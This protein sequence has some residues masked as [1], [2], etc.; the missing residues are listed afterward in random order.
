MSRGFSGGKFAIPRNRGRVCL[1]QTIEN[2][3]FFLED[4][5]GKLWVERIIVTSLDAEAIED[6]LTANSQVMT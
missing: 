2:E 3:N 6:V 1:F 4:D 5:N